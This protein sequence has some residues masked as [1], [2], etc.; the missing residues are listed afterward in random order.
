MGSRRMGLAAGALAML[1]AAGPLRAAECDK[2]QTQADLNICAE[3]GFRKA[4]AELNAVYGLLLKEPEMV[5]RL[6]R[7]KA[8]ER[9]WVGYRDAQCAFAGSANEGGSM[10]GMVVQ[11]CAR[12]LTERR[13][14][15]LKSDLACS[16]NPSTC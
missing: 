7:L 14:A 16:R 12:G 1:A 9:A 8:A 10:Q 4:D 2:A 5:P 11:S 13:T 6:D 15:E 3:G